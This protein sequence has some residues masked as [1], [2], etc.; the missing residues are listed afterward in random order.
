MEAAMGGKNEMQSVPAGSDLSTKQYYLVTIN[1][2]GQLATTGDGAYASGVLQNEPA[3]AG[4]AGAIVTRGETR[5]VAGGAFNA[6]ELLGSDSSGKAVNA[7]TND[8]VIG[9]ALAASL[10]DGDIVRIQFFGGAGTKALA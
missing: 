10:A 6:G 4:R 7:A 2:S 3:A 1:S 8:A 5:V 9:Q